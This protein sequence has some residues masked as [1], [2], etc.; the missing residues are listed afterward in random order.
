LSTSVGSWGSNT[1]TWTNVNTTYNNGN[2]DNGNYWISKALD[3]YANAYGVTFSVSAGNNL[4]DERIYGPGGG[5]NVVTSGG[6]DD[7]DAGGSPFNFELA[8]FTP[9]IKTPDGRKKPDLVFSAVDIDAYN[10]TAQE[11]TI[12]GNSFSAPHGAGTSAVIG[13]NWG[14]GVRTHKCTMVNGVRASGTQWEFGWGWGKS[15]TLNA[16]NTAYKFIDSVDHQQSRTWQDIFVYQG[17][18]LYTTLIW[19]R[20][21]NSTTTEWRVSDLDLNIRD[22]NGAILRTSNSAVDTVERTVYTAPSGG[23]TVDI[24]VYGYDTKG[25]GPQAFVLCYDIR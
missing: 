18:T 19:Y 24:E 3:R 12:S 23:K 7:F 4:P 9:S 1:G 2:G 13:S 5:Y 25:K 16:M 15:Y 22:Q 10:R 14:G 6:Y 17:L 20:E 8:S 21:M 11:I